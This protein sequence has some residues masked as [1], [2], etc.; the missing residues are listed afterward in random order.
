ML[1]WSR[2]IRLIFVKFTL[3][4]F[5]RLFCMSQRW[6]K[7][8]YVNSMEVLCLEKMW[9]IEYMKYT[10]LPNTE[11][12]CI[13]NTIHLIAIFSSM[14]LQSVMTFSETMKEQLS[15]WLMYVH[16][17]F[18]LWNNETFIFMYL[19]ILDSFELMGHKCLMVC[20]LPWNTSMTCYRHIYIIIPLAF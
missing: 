8:V 19:S 20:L 10:S 1:C 15:Y 12:M 11:R 18:S 4:P 5:K 16:C 17:C 9:L 13:R 2:I 14:W 6:Q 3:N 7:K